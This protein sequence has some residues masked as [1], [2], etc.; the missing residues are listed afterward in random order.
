MKVGASLP[1]KGKV[2]KAWMETNG[3]TPSQKWRAIPIDDHGGFT[4]VSDGFPAPADPEPWKPE[5][6]FRLRTPNPVIAAYLEHVGPVVGD[7][8]PSCSKCGAPKEGTAQ[9]FVAPSHIEL[10]CTRCGYAWRER[11]V[12]SVP[13]AETLWRWVKRDTPVGG[14]FSLTPQSLEERQ[15][16]DERWK[17]WHERLDAAEAR[18]AEWIREQYGGNP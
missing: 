4:Y 5:W 8:S 3:V 11:T 16:E 1:W 12:D 10:A 13:D 14:W 2:R 15:Q 18:L 17:G 6:K 7:R 9:R